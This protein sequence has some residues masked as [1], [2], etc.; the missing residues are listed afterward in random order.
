MVTLAAPVGTFI[1][2]LLR[3]TPSRRTEYAQVNLHAFFIRPCVRGRVV[4]ASDSFASGDMIQATQW[5]S[6]HPGV[7]DAM[8]N[9]TQLLFCYSF[10]RSA[11]YIKKGQFNCG[12]WNWRRSVGPCTW[13]LWWKVAL[14]HI[15][16]WI[17][18]S[19]LSVLFQQF[20]MLLNFSFTDAI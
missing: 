6:R 17:F 11:S 7:A 9:R 5:D 1:P 20:S 8:T 14:R 3:L 2:S 13:N 19:L 12:S 16:L 10:Y 4:R 15:L 18:G